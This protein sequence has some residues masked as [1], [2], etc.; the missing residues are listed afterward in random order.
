MGRIAYVN[1]RYGP[2]PDAAVHIEDR[3]FQFADGVYEVWAVMGGRLSDAEGHFERLSRSLGELRIREPMTRAALTQVLRETIRRNHLK[4]GLL[5]LQITR[6]AARRD[7]AFPSPEVAPTVVITARPADF[8]ALERKAAAGA[9]VITQPEIRWGRCDIKTVGLLPNALAKQAAKEAGAG[10]AWFVDADGY[11]TEGSST[12]AWIVDGEGRL[13]T[14]DTGA[15]ILR[16]VTRK[17]LIELARECQLE[18]V[19]KPFTLAEAK[20]AKEAFFTAASAFVTPVTAI[21]GEPVG[22]GRPGPV[23][24]RLRD[25]Y[26]RR[27]REGAM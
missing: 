14:R 13:C 4:D 18:V 11:V 2:L 17:T 9:R 16:G 5:Y 8:D 10:E 27:A 20:A 7:H 1:G 25:L 22:D 3:G 23:T 12:N 21:D 15:N 19:E 24:L 26:T 6:G